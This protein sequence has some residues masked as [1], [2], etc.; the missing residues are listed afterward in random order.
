[1]ETVVGIFT[2]LGDAKQ[3]VEDLQRN[4][5]ANDKINL[6]VPGA[7]AD[8]L[9][10]VPKTET[11][12]PGMGKAL[13]AV[14]GT[15]LGTAG[16]AYLGM[17]AATALVSGV[18]PVVAIGLVASSL[19]G[20]GGALGGAAAGGALEDA[21]SAGLP[22]DELFVYEDALR[23]GRTIIVV[24]TDN[25]HQAEVA[26]GILLRRGAESI[27][28]ARERW[29][30]GLRS[31]EEEHYAAA[32]EELKLVEANFRLGFEAALHPE[33]RARSYDDAIAYLRE[34]YPGKYTQKSFRDGYERGQQYWKRTQG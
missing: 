27:D 26:R 21:L 16:G 4:G 14:V 8:E 32:G 2:T 34:R 15:G 9:R 25:D 12:Q 28:S 23:Q 30:I 17:A 10:A 22:K 6:L 11:E 7:S 3:A 13:G 19:L 31:A 24:L 29:W 33:I 20:I 5:V 1:L 18:G